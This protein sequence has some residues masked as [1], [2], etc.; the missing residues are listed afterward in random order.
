MNPEPYLSWAI[1]GLI[2]VI[3]ELVTGTFYLVMLGVAAFGAA[4]AAYLGYDFP[5]QSN[6]C[7]VGR[8]GRRVL[9]PRLSRQ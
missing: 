8:R 7:S 4:A 5:V 2:L 1:L 6:R 9:G 3:A